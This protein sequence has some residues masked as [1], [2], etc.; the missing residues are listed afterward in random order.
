MIS[1]NKGEKIH[2]KLAPI[3]HNIL[4]QLFQFVGSIILLHIALKKK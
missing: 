4:L 2:L 3:N 1:K